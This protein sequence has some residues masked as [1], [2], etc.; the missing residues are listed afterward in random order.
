M[1]AACDCSSS[2]FHQ[3]AYRCHN[4]Q[5]LS[6]C[7]CCW[8]MQDETEGMKM[9]KMLPELHIGMYAA[10][11]I[12]VGSHDCPF[13]VILSRY[14]DIDYPHIFHSYESS[15]RP[16]CQIRSVAVPS[17]T[18]WRVWGMSHTSCFHVRLHLS[19][20]MCVCYQDNS[21]SEIFSGE[22]FSCNIWKKF[23]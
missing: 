11:Q 9:T 4:L 2:C 13:I 7:S 3:S 15:V 14:R 20:N 18:C 21:S 5:L 8:S 12:L 6:R 19:L 10:W 1:S 23:H 16:E 17:S 22:C